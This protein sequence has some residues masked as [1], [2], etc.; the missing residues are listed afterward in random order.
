LSTAAIASAPT[1]MTK[2]RG[3]NKGRDKKRRD[4][5]CREKNACSDLTMLCSFGREKLESRSQAN[6]LKTL[7]TNI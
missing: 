4:A 2:E 7:M 5:R 6:S 3:G 1:A